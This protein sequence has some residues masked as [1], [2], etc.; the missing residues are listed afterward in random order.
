MAKK[1]KEA[2]NGEMGSN[3]VRPHP[4]LIEPPPTL[5]ASEL[6]ALFRSY[7]Q[8]NALVEQARKALDGALAARSKIVEQ[9]SNGAG[10][11]P[12]AYKG[13][14]LTVVCRT[15]KST[16]QATWFFKGPSKNDVTEVS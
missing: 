4:D 1:K 10:R 11:G 9:I 6:K 13:Q 14:V 8:T 15:A 2:P 12:F 7:D 16:G 3:N 5:S